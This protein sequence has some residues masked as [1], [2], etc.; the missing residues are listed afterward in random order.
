MANIVVVET[1]ARINVDFGDYYGVVPQVDFQCCSYQKTN[2]D[3]VC[4]DVGYCIV[5]MHNLEEWHVAFDLQPDCF[6]VDTV[7][8][9]APTDNAHL[10]ELL[11][12]L[13]E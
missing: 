13:I 10:Y 5:K 2:L 6:I 8:G 3:A 9:I 11:G 12:S 7:N 4:K 1:G